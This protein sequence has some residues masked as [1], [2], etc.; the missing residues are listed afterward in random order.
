LL[1]VIL[2][3]AF[4]S[5]YCVYQLTSRPYD[6]VPAQVGQKKS[7]VI[8]NTAIVDQM[9]LTKAEWESCLDP[10]QTPSVYLSIV[11]VT[12]VDDYAG[13]KKKLQ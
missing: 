11:I 5:L 12:R 8:E 13:Y 4:A 1:P 10:G 3:F 7:Y 9:Q 6:H 2:V